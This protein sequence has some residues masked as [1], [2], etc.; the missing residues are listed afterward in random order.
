[1]SSRTTSGGDGDEL[2]GA[3]VLGSQGGEAVGLFGQGLPAG[4]GPGGA[5]VLGSD[6]YIS[7]EEERVSPADEEKTNEFMSSSSSVTC[8]LIFR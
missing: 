1:M 6:T 8:S 4:V 5:V 7:E 2:S 3:A